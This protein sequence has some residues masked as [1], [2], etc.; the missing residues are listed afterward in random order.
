MSPADPLDRLIADWLS[1]A[2]SPEDFRALDERLRTDS[3]A[4]ATLRRAA[5]LDAALRDWAT[6]HEVS[7]A[8]ADADDP[9]IERARTP[10]SI[11]RHWRS[12][13]AAAVAVLFVRVDYRRQAAEAAGG[14]TAAEAGGGDGD[15][16]K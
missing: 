1:N 15:E 10:P 16:G 9:A 7:A 5:N 14:P 12:L 13:L 2:I 8:W 4:R 11:F 6:R 3:A